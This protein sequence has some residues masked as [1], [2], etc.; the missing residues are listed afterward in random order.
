MIEKYIHGV[1]RAH[2]EGHIVFQDSELAPLG[3]SDEYAHLAEKGGGM[4][5][6]NTRP[7]PG[8]TSDAISFVA[9]RGQ[10]V[11]VL[12]LGHGAG[13][14]IASVRRQHRN[15][16]IHTIGLT[17]VNPYWMPVGGREDAVNGKLQVEDGMLDAYT[18]NPDQLMQRQRQG[19][20]HMFDECERPFIDRQVVGFLEKTTRMDFDSN[21]Y[22]VVAEH[23]GALRYATHPNTFEAVPLKEKLRV[24][25]LVYDLLSPD[26]VFVT[27]EI[28]P[29][30]RAL[31]KRIMQKGD[32]MVRVHIGSVERVLLAKA[33]FLLDSFLQKIRPREVEKLF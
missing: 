27:N 17:P 3:P 21:G 1:E 19:N 18:W 26:G 30:N 33:P 6:F 9:S 11:R 23:S 28:Q 15:A 5:G 4:N 29:P 20:V 14:A 7:L 2:R 24:C 22:R 31:F 25:Q 8:V 32:A 16:L 12:E 10:E 13:T